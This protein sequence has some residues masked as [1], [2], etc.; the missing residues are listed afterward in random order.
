MCWLVQHEKHNIKVSRPPESRW[1]NNTMQ[2]Y[3]P[4]YAHI[5]KQFHPPI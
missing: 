1:I 3:T 2:Q 5:T 4:C